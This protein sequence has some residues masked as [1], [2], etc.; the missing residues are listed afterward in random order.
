MLAL[1]KR[2]LN[3]A[4]RKGDVEVIP[5]TLHISMPTVDNKVTEDLTPEQARKLLQSLD[6]EPDQTLASLVRWAL[7]TGMRRGA[8]LNLQWQDVDFERGFITLRGEVAKKGKTETIPMNE[9]AR[10]I[11][12]AMPQTRSPMSFPVAMMTS[13]AGRISRPF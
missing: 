6:E 9:Q 13:G 11:L 2:L 7:L 1:I 12:S 10:A 5:G 8:L 3:F 4:L